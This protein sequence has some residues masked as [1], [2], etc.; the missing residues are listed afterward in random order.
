MSSKKE[1]ITGTDIVELILVDHKPL[2]DL[3]KILKKPDG[4]AV[5][6]FD[7]FET[8]APLLLAHA[9]PEEM[10][11]YEF[12]KKDKQ[13]LVDALEGDTEHALASQLI[14]EIHATADKDLWSAK[15]KVLAEMV[16]HHIRE[17]EGSML[18]DFRKVTTLEERIVLGD[19]YTQLKAQAGNPG[20]KAREAELSPA[21]H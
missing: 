13:M 3:I 1:E 11:L 19:E 14:D 21:H 18:P 15:V 9:E 7:A 12:M 6:R 20:F 10:S 2:K 8:F 5:E 17:E 16:E 4:D